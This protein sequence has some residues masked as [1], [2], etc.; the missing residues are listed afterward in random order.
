M[1]PT[2]DLISFH[3]YSDAFFNHSVL[4]LSDVTQL[5]V[6][7]AASVKW[8]KQTNKKK[9]PSPVPTKKIHLQ[10]IRSLRTV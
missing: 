8:G 9:T 1:L 6:R 3:F 2:T 7:P 4:A 5:P 10:T